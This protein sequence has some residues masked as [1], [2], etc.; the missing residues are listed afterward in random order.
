MKK[1]NLFIL[2]LVLIVFMSVLFSDFC[3]AQILSGNV[4]KEDFLEKSHIVVDGATGNPVSGAEVSIPSAGIFAKTND[5][6][7]FKL[8]G[9]FNS[10]MI[11]SV[12]ADGY[13][14]FSIT[15]NEGKI[16]NPLTIAISKLFGNEMVIDS[17]IH[18]LGDDNFSEKSANAE[19]FKLKAESP[20]F[21]KEFFVEKLDSNSNPILKIGTIIGLDTKIAHRVAGKTGIKAYSS[22]IR[23]YINSKKIGDI[24]ING[25]NQEIPLS[26]SILKQNSTNTIRIE[27]GVNQ[28]AT[29]YID[30]DDM[31][32]MN[33]LLIF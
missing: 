3:N 31:E 29:S 9:S 4:N 8:D 26:K 22:A 6:G 25:D 27:T 12:Q 18:H 24:K 7:Q 11:L 15:I 16:S 2:S 10:P 1:F 5:S 30:Y 21:F 13:K 17:E 19:D 32:F 33:I 20:D 23:V 28:Q 14:P